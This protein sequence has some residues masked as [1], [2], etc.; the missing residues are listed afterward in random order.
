VGTSW[1]IGQNLIILA[2]LNETNT[3][4][5]HLHVLRRLIIPGESIYIREHTT[6]FNKASALKD[7]SQLDEIIGKCLEKDRNL[8]YQHASDLCADLQR[9]KRDT[10]LSRQVR[11]ASTSQLPKSFASSAA[12]LRGPA[13]RAAAIFARPNPSGHPQK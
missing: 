10:E 4:I 9:L 12:Q 6:W 5:A 1:E 11:A 8:R 13:E 3:A 7:N 2:L